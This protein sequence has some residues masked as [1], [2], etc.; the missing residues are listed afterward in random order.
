VVA[1]RAWIVAALG[2]ALIASTGAGSLLLSRKAPNATITAVPHWGLYSPTTWN[3]VATKFEQRGFSGA[4]VHVVTGTKLAGTGKS[5][6]ILGARSGSGRNCFAVAR[7]TT[8]G[9]TICTVSK[10]LVVFAARDLCV[11]CA[12]GRSPLKTLTILSLVRRDVTSVTMIDRGHESGVVISP[13]GGGTYA[14]NSGAALNNAV[15]R[16]RGKGAS[17]LAQVPVHLP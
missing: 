13:A 6:A 9:A 5:F 1:N 4:S 17:I 3:V 11:A 10:P 14:F 7:G 2:V 15:L 8:L 12:P 16:A